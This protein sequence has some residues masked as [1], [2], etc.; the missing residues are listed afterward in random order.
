[1]AS[2]VKEGKLEI[3]EKISAELRVVD[4]EEE[5]TFLIKAKDD[6]RKL[7]QRTRIRGRRGKSFR[8]TNF[9]LTSTLMANGFFPMFCSSS[10]S[11]V[12]VIVMRHLIFTLNRN[13]HNHY[14]L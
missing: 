9:Y 11:A 14:I 1:M 4:G 13:V 6:K 8:H 5:E 2:R 10:Q 3:N 7:Q 12:I